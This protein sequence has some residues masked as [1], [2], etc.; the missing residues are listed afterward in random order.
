MVRGQAG[1]RDNAMAAPVQHWLIHAVQRARAVRPRLDLVPFERLH[2]ANLWQNQY[3]LPYS[4]MVNST[5]IAN[6]RLEVGAA[7][8]WPGRRC[9]T[10]RTTPR[11]WVAQSPLEVAYNFGLPDPTTA[12]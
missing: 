8:V 12:D 1:V 11:G 5:H 10:S 7:Q 9:G 2:V 6:K 4:V 3:E